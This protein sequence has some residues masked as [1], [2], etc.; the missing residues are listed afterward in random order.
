MENPEPTTPDNYRAL[1]EVERPSLILR[2]DREDVVVEV[3]LVQRMF[4][5]ERGFHMV[6]E[7]AFKC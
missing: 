1:V 6:Q 3:H 7:V 4:R 5:L 2:S